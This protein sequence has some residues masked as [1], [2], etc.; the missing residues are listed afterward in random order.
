MKFVKNS[1][2]DEALEKAYQ[3]GLKDGSRI[4]VEQLAFATKRLKA[5]L[6]GTRTELLEMLVDFKKNS[7]KMNAHSV[8]LA[9][10]TKGNIESL[11][12]NAE[13]AFRSAI[14]ELLGNM[15]METFY[16]LWKAKDEQ[17][18]RNTK[19]D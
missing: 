18:K 11:Y 15:D 4:R 8:S 16:L 14:R 6:N 17:D 1:T 9:K 5:L 10:S 3:K 7:L 12:S 2:Y 19:K 13:E